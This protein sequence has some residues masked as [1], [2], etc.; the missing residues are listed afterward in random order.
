MS[1]ICDVVEIKKGGYTAQVSLQDELYENEINQS[2]MSNY[3][4]IKSHRNAFEN[5]ANG[6]FE[7]NNKRVFVLEGSYGTGKSHLCLMFANYLS[8]NSENPS[9]QDFFDNFLEKAKDDISENELQSLIGKLERYKGVRK[10]DKKYLVAL[11]DYYSDD[12]FREIVLKS[13]LNAIKQEGL[14]FDNFDTIY[15]EAIRKIKEFE[16]IENS[17]GRTFYSDFK[18]ELKNYM[19][20]RDIEGFLKGLSNIEVN[21]L[22]TFKKIFKNLTT[23]D[24][25]YDKDN[26]VDIIKETI[27]SD[28]FKDKFSGIIIIF[29]EFDKILKTQRFDTHIFQGFGQF[30]ANSLLTTGIPVIFLS[31]THRA[32]R[33][34]KSQYNEEDFKTVSDRLT[35]I[36]LSTEG[37]EDIMSAIVRQKKDSQLWQSTIGEKKREFISLTQKS[38]NNNLFSWLKPK[39]IEEKIIKDLFPMHP[40]TTY[41]LL[42]LAKVVGSN[43]RSVYTFFTD[44]SDIKGSFSNFIESNDI[45]EKDKLNFLTPD[46]LIDYFGEKKF[47]SD[48]KELRDNIRQI[49]LDY[50]SSYKEYKKNSTNQLFQDEL[51]VKILK[52]ILVY[53]ISGITLTKE[54]IYFGLLCNTKEEEISVG[55]V[56]DTMKTKSI[57]FFN[58]ISKTYEFKKSDTLDINSVISDFMSREENWNFNLINELQELAE[59]KAERKL[60][61]IF[62]AD[63]KITADE[64]NSIYLEDKLFIKKYATVADIKSESFFNS[65]SG[66]IISQDFPNGKYEGTVVIILCENNDEVEIAHKYSR[67]INNQRIILGIPTEFYPIKENVVKVLATKK[68]EKLNTDLTPQETALLRDYRDESIKILI[69]SIKETEKKQNLTWYT[70]TE[71]FINKDASDVVGNVLEIIYQNKRTLIKNQYINKKYEINPNLLKSLK[72]VVDKILIENSI[73]YNRNASDST[74]DK[75]FLKDFKDLNILKVIETKDSSDILSLNTDY[76]Q[77]RSVIPSLVYL[78]EEI[79]EHKKNEILINTWIDLFYNTYGLGKPA[80]IFIFSLLLSSKKGFIVYKENPAS[81]IEEEINSYE[82]LE[83]IINNKRGI[84][85][86]IEINENELKFIENL[87]G[88]FGE[89]NLSERISIFK[90]YKTLENWF[91]SLEK[92]KK[93]PEYYTKD[94]SNL[95]NTLKSMRSFSPETFLLKELNSVISKEKDELLSN[96]DYEKLL[97]IFKSFKGEINLVDF[98]IKEKVKKEFENEF[99]L[100]EQDSFLF[101]KNKFENLDSF[102]KDL[103]K[104]KGNDTK[105]ALQYLNKIDKNNWETEIITS[106]RETLS[107]NSYTEWVSDKISESIN[108]LKTA[109]T[110][111]DNMYLIPKPKLIFEG[112]YEESGFNKIYFGDSFKIKVELEEEYNEEISIAYT[113][114]GESPSTA[115]GTMDINYVIKGNYILGINANKKT[116]KII[117]LIGTHKRSDEI[118]VDLI[119]LKEKFK[120]EV[121][122]ENTAL[123]GEKSEKKESIKFN[124]VPKD[125]KEVKT[126][127]REL[128]DFYISRNEDVNTE[129]IKLAIQ[130]LIDEL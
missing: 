104:H 111:L 101:L 24:F 53:S 64:Y 121:I 28:T 57:I 37:F 3:M 42:Q 110:R 71:K 84:F 73:S 50:E 70:S 108:L 79:K 67:N 10:S 102:K 129:N 98:K 6:L 119:P 7:Q 130:E 44:N 82:R 120:P 59:D 117:S 35:E 56:L 18:A 66:E 90:C 81:T 46:I 93:I 116:L 99:Q 38:K 118:I 86:L 30:C 48:N 39:K 88:L 127:I 23:N 9:I 1:K 78:M 113:L 54:N 52:L 33:S 105:A 5:I 31:T 103:D 16:S 25:I 85:K 62:K 36:S 89:K 11:C 122:R 14:S 2:R 8:L 34:Y 4:P 27:K 106:F 51:F 43:N 76:T 19:P 94:V 65:L 58:E 26:L 112:K 20:G 92:Y 47:S 107:Y 97:E 68:S 74:G 13:I 17:G 41:S 55:S 128:L 22:E 29:D 61:N 87:Y 96:S 75:R 124:F 60:Y 91:D 45:I 49:V 115:G 69:N 32:F 80:I 72:E 83:D 95:I 21:F 125:I 15:H 126:A 109:I 63:T 40:L 77:Y 123:F 100:N 12:N 114:N